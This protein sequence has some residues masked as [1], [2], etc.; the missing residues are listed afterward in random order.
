MDF[1]PIGKE[2]LN[3]SSE[4]SNLPSRSTGA[5]QR[6]TSLAKEALNEHN[7][8]IKIREIQSLQKQT[9]MKN[10]QM[11]AI[12]IKNGFKIEDANKISI[13]TWNHG[14]PLDREEAELMLKNA[15]KGSWL[16]R[17]SKNANSYVV[18]KLIEHG[19]EA[20]IPPPLFEHV[21]QSQIEKSGVSIENLAKGYS[22][23]YPMRNML[24]NNYVL[25]EN[26]YNLGEITGADA[27]NMLEIAPVGTW[28]LRY[29]KSHGQYVFTVKLN[30]TQYKHYTI[31]NDYN[32]ETG[33]IDFEELLYETNKRTPPDIK[34]KF[35]NNL[36]VV[37]PQYR[38]VKQTEA[39]AIGLFL[40]EI[41]RNPVH[42]ENFETSGFVKVSRSTHYNE[43]RSSFIIRNLGVK[44]D[45]EGRPTFIGSLP[46]YDIKIYQ[47]IH[48][49]T[50][51]L[52]RGT[53]KIAKV[54]VD[55]ETRE[56]VVKSKFQKYTAAQIESEFP[57]LSYIL[58]SREIIPTN[59]LTL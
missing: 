21:T 47:V 49:P 14:D 53:W 37:K 56:R 38:T 30:E 46:N 2:P 6:L 22:A 33:F 31:D 16:L 55:L 10:E 25:E 58:I 13:N 43:L 29:S 26:L 3:V 50:G 35:S 4:K 28:L 20:G 19:G 15:P 9:G 36:G 42:Q 32:K 34:L 8:E 54:I 24:L 52:G 11:K 23:R 48:G 5:E 18:S 17:F 40:K 57:E 12:L 59:T 1:N 45:A 41:A 44:K 39:I 27:K 51:I 7:F